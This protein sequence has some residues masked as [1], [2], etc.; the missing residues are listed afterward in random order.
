MSLFR[1]HVPD[2]VRT[3]RKK[4]RSHRWR[5][6]VDSLRFIA[7]DSEAS[8]LDTAKDR[9]L[10]IATIEIR[11][12]QI[13]MDGCHQWLVCQPDTVPNKATEV[14]GILPAQLEGGTEEQQMM[15]E[16]L[17]HIT[18]AI[19]VGHNIWFDARLLDQ[20]LRRH[21]HTRLRNW[22]LDVGTMSMGEL[23]PF[24]ES[25]YLNQRTPSL[26]DIC[27][28]LGLPMHDRHTS[29]GDA[30]IAAEIFLLLY[31]RIRR[32]LKPPPRLWDLPVKRP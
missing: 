11:D 10:S 17:P 19:L 8:G 2:A 5:S 12:G 21:F 16:I 7:L 14:H 3:Y 4:T 30:Y 23:A 32:R 18:N 31:G 1:N 24:K 28:H 29:M 26:E 6:P 13:S 27:A 25:G 22:T 15:E 9:I 20:A